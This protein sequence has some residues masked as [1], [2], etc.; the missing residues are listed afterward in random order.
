M[1]T[2]PLDPA[3]IAILT[4]KAMIL[5][6][7]TP[8]LGPFF[9][10]SCLGCCCCSGSFLCSIFMCSPYCCLKQIVAP[11]VNNVCC[12]AA[13]PCPCGSTMFHDMDFEDGGIVGKDE[14]GNK[15]RMEVVC[16]QQGMVENHIRDF[17]IKFRAFEMEQQKLIF[18]E[19]LIRENEI[20]RERVVSN[21]SD[22]ERLE[23]NKKDLELIESSEK[24][25]RRYKDQLQF[26]K[27]EAQRKS[28]TD[29]FKSA[30][31]LAAAA[32]G[33]VV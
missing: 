1:E 27:E 26:N 24:D 31:G 17:Q 6:N 29:G 8:T 5:S 22:A 4:E 20:L 21:M 25:E 9:A 10:E 19:K 7:Y 15:I 3:D 13:I 18:K 2:E 30:S 12:C 11:T 14:K 33:A 16:C 28:A 32:L 23:F